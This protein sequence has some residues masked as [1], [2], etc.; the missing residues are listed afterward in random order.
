MI[1]TVTLNAAV[2]KTY[3]VDHFTLDRV[4]RTGEFRVAAGGKGINVA[5]V[6]HA[7]GGEALATGFLGGYNGRYI[8]RAARD[9]GIPTR[10][11]RTAEESRVCI[12]IVDPA[13]CTQT[14]VNE[15]GPHVRP[16]EVTA[17][18]RLFR[19]LLS[20]TPF[21]FVTLS[22]SIPPG[23]PDTIYAELIEIA[24]R[25]GV[26]CVLDASGE[27]LRAGFAARPWMV[28]PNGYELAM[29]TGCSMSTV[30]EREM[31]AQ[32]RTLAG[33]GPEVVAVTLGSKGCLCVAE[34]GAAAWRAVPPHI[35]FVSAVGSGDSF[36]GAFLW[37]LGQ[38]WTLPEAL[39]LAVG[40]GAANAT[41]YGSGFCCAESIH[42]LAARTCVEAV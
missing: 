35:A 16:T 27:P 10:I 4:H 14:E 1:L 34:G 31:L 19:R 21:E 39:R 25:A 38:R 22:G 28:K 13:A 6:Y 37:A 26:R 2:D 18:R 17:L 8:A 3:R 9:E 23:V 40:A 24:R 30:D 12:A 20:E 11:V 15:A 33:T 42:A 29:L 5:R 32:I 41:V 36:L 7:L